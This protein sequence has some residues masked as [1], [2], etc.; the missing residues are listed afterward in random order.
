MIIDAIKSY[1]ENECDLF[2]GKKLNVNCLSEKVHSCV[3]ELTPSKPLIQKYTDGSSL[4]QKTFM[5][6][7][8]EFFDNETIQNLQTA[9]FYE[10]FEEFILKQNDTGN[11]PKLDDG[12]TSVE[13]EILNSGYVQ[14]VTGNKARYQINLRLIYLRD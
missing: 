3:I 11:L 6:A 14:D 5:I 12:Y 10:M 4:N 13:L 7:T 1:F 8:R 9:Q 2:T